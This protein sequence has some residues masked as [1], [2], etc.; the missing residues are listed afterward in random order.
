MGGLIDGKYALINGKLYQTITNPA[1][2]KRKL[3]DAG[4]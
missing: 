1:I 4:Q 3:S 2:G